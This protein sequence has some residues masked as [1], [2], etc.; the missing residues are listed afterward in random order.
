MRELYLLYGVPHPHTT[1][2]YPQANGLVEKSNRALGD[3]LMTLLL[4]RGLEE[5][6]LLFPQVPH[7]IMKEMS[8]LMMLVREARLP[9]T[10]QYNPSPRACRMSM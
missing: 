4:D 9:D 8:N 5:W 6:D 1:L 3:L 10:L 7:S 2:Y